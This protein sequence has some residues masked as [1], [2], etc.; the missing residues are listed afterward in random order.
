MSL[1]QKFESMS[2]GKSAK[3]GIGLGTS[4]LHNK[5]ILKA[6][7][8]FLG[9]NGSRIYIFGNRR[10]ILSIN[11]KNSYKN[12]KL[13]INFIEC[14]EA[15]KNIFE[16][17]NNNMIDAI[18]RGSLSSNKF[19]GNLRKFLNVQKINRLAFLETADG[20][21]FFY[22]PVGFDECNNLAD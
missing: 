13:N 5:K 17:L 14:E 16:S 15:E 21:L 1:L 9:E 7:I 20:H 8:D 6:C 2:I 22:G 12:R 3:I 18:I 4:E 11:K 10:A 19:L